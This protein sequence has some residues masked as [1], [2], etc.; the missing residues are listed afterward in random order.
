MF[1]FICNSHW[2]SGLLR[3]THDFCTL[4]IVHEEGAGN[5]HQLHLHVDS[6]QAYGVQRH[7]TKTTAHHPNSLWQLS[8][9]CTLFVFMWTSLMKLVYLASINK[10][11][12][13][14]CI[15]KG[16]VTLW[17]LEL[18]AKTQVLHGLKDETIVGYLPLN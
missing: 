7:F 10:A 11:F 17:E 13:S 9:S 15:C 6:H 1:F 5:Q 3:F 18:Q 16:R 8:Q 2:A 12:E 4:Q 14:D